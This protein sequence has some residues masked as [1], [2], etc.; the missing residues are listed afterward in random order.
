LSFLESD[1]HLL[2]FHDILTGCYSRRY[3]TTLGEALIEDARSRSIPLVLSFAD[4]DGLKQIN[5]TFGHRMGDSLLKEIARILEFDSGD[6]SVGRFGGD[7]F[8]V[9]SL[10]IPV[11]E[12]A[13]KADAARR[14]VKKILQS[15]IPNARV[16]L[17]VGI[18]A[19]PKDGRTFQALYSVAE[20]ANN[21]GKRR[22]GDCVVL[23]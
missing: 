18:S 4:V 8:L 3:M 11:T 7:E 13:E 12:V 21:K 5:E 23:S 6:C 2:G 10:G 17:T 9:C 1:Y 16:S 19:H 20:E 15:L 22:G 14:L